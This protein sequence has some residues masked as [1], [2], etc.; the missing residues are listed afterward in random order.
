[1]HSNPGKSRQPSWA[2]WAACAAWQS[3]RMAW[4]VQSVAG[5]KNALPEGR[6]PKA[7]EA[8]P[9]ASFCA[10]LQSIRSSL[11][12]L[13]YIHLR[14]V[15]AVPVHRI[16]PVGLIRSVDAHILVPYHLQAR[17]RS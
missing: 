3:V 15:A 17:K 9:V 12:K 1:M 13:V 7:W 16:Q 11:L 2:C 5:A 10:L 4:D 14:R 6:L 8:V